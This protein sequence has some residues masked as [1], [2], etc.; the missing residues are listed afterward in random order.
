MPFSDF[1]PFEQ[2]WKLAVLQRAVLTHGNSNFVTSLT[3][4][5]L[6]IYPPIYDSSHLSFQ[7]YTTHPGSLLKSILHAEEFWSVVPMC[8]IASGISLPL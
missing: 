3:M 2:S 8:K 5:W 7:F 1:P 4:L 6:L